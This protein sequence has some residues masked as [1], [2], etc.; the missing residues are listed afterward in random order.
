MLQSYNGK[1]YYVSFTDDY[2]RWMT[3]Y[4]ISQKSEVLAK[5]KEYEAWMRTQYSKPIKVLQSDRG[6]EYLSKEFDNHLKVNGTIRSLIMHD[7]PEE[8][9]VAKRLNH[10]LLEHARAMLMTAQLPKTL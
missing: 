8:N 3:I 9:G 1:L 10:M 5:Y 4:C 7:T 6:G 2:T